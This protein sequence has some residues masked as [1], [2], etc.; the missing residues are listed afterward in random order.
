MS[1]ATAEGA[2]ASLGGTCKGPPIR[3][4][5]PKGAPAGKLA[6]P[7]LYRAEWKF[8]TPLDALGAVT[9]SEKRVMEA[10]FADSLEQAIGSAARAWS[11]C[12]TPFAEATRVGV[13]NWNGRPIKK[14]IAEDTD[15]RDN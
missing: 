5:Y 14:K 3:T 9:T 7:N 10:T 11:D 12:T 2:K 6:F 13:I 1:A 8:L 15:G 4:N